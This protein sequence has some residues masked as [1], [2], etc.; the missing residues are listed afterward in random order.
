[1]GD[2]AGP[3]H[4]PVGSGPDIVTHGYREHTIELRA[5]D[6]LDRGA[7]GKLLADTAMGVI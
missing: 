7:D 1:M 3:D 6:T 4:A 2:R 5:F